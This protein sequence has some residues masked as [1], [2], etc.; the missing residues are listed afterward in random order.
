MQ[1]FLFFLILCLKA[2]LCC[3]TKVTFVISVV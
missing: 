2:K 3:N 1:A